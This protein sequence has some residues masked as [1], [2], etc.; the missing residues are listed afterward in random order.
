MSSAAFRHG[1]FEMLQRGTFVGVF[2]GEE[3]TRALNEGL[4][5]D[6]SRTSARA[7]LF[8]EDARLRAFTLP[9]VPQA[10]RPVVEILPVQ[11]MTLALAALGN[12]EAGRFERATKVTVI[13]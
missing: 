6:L 7:E 11:M 4:M 8:S 9:K 13:E 2:A 12:R 10:L 3:R 5:Q 1:P